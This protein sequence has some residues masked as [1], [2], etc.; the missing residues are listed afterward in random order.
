MNESVN[1]NELSFQ[2]KVSVTDIYSQVILDRGTPE[3]YK[4]DGFRP[5]S[6]GDKFIDTFGLVK[7]ASDD[8]P[9]TQHSPR[10]ILKP[11]V[12]R[13]VYSFT[14]TGEKRPLKAGEWGWDGSVMLDNNSHV[15]NQYSDYRVYKMVKSY[16]WE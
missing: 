8:A 13:A 3:G 10:F 2:V 11:L 7:T 4:I 16:V 5:P 14:E 15:F 9:V 1:L 6:T 12:K